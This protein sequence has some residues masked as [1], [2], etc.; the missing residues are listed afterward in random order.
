MIQGGVHVLDRGN[1]ERWTTF[2]GV[3]SSVQM[4]V[5][6]HTHS[7]TYK[8]NTHVYVHAHTNMHV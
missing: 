7:H 5:Y 4:C 2:S 8:E 3:S 6:T 1:R